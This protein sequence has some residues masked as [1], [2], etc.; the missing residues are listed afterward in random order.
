MNWC[1]CRRRAF[2]ATC[3]VQGGHDRGGHGRRVDDLR[4]CSTTHDQSRQAAPLSGLDGATGN[5][6][7]DR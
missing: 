2:H 5:G 1:E 7:L 6:R 3:T 4:L